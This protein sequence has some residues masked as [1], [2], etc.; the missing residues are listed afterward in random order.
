MNIKE[1]TIIV[2][3]EEAKHFIQEHKFQENEIIV[4]ESAREL[5]REKSEE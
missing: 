1:K 5:E 3:K 4:I 2:S